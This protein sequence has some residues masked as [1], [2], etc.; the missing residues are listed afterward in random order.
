MYFME[1][2]IDYKSNLSILEKQEVYM[3]YMSIFE[4]GFTDGMENAI[5][6]PIKCLKKLGFLE[7]TIKKTNTEYDL[8]NQFKQT[9]AYQSAYFKGKIVGIISTIMTAGA[10]SIGFYLNNNK[11]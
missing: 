11:K 4:L 6:F 1:K 10:F 7:K 9:T 2:L 5:V 8:N 3:S